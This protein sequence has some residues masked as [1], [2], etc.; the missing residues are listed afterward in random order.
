MHDTWFFGHI[1]DV[2]LEFVDPEQL[3]E[4]AVREEFASCQWWRPDDDEPVLSGVRAKDRAISKDGSGWIERLRARPR[5]EARTEFLDDLYTAHTARGILSLRERAEELDM[6][7]QLKDRLA[8]FHRF[9]AAKNRAREV[10]ARDLAR[11]MGFRIPSPEG[12]FTPPTED[13][14]PS[15]WLVVNPR[16]WRGTSRV[17][18]AAEWDPEREVLEAREPRSLDLIEAAAGCNAGW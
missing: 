7:D 6:V 5:A 3:E 15:E 14:H 13:L 11:D 16:G 4:M 1:N 9:Q 18:R 12:D 17:I 8:M 10:R 2:Q